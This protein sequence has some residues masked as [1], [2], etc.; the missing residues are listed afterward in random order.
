MLIP[1]M[2]LPLLVAFF[3]LWSCT[4]RVNSITFILKVPARSAECFYEQTT[5]EDAEIDIGV[6]VVKGGD[7]GV[8]LNIYN[9]TNKEILSKLVEESY[10]TVK[11]SLSGNAQVFKICL[12][13]SFSLW[14][15][16][17][18]YFALSVHERQDHVESTSEFLDLGLDNDLSYE[19]SLMLKNVEHRLASVTRQLSNVTSIQTYLKV[20]EARQRMVAVDHNRQVLMWS[21][22]EVVVMVFAA[23]IQVITTRSILR[24]DS[25]TKLRT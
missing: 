12:D 24:T 25:H 19:H 5:E 21:V 17:M 16:K 18:V 22:L 7:F 3:A 13:N 9:S 6:Q 10:Y 23:L 1:A 14:V 8:R 4:S 20:R 2:Q 11:L 15:A